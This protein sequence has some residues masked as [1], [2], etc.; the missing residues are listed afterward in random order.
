[1][2]ITK[3]RCHCHASAHTGVAI[4][5]DKL[6]APRLQSTTGNKAGGDRNQ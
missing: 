5:I 1:M 4:P 6:T 2:Q 3:M